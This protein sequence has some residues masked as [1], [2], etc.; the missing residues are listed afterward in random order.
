MRILALAFV[1]ALAAP[2]AAAAEFSIDMAELRRLADEVPGAKP[3]EIRV[4]TLGHFVTPWSMVIEGG[5]AATV[6]MDLL[7][8][9]L[10]L[11][12]KTL[13]IDTALG[14]ALVAQYGIE[15]WDA[16]ASARLD[17]AMANADTIIV[18]HEHFDHIGRIVA[19]ASDAGLMARTRLTAEQVARPQDMEGVEWPEGVLATY[20][21]LTYER[22]HALAP[23]VVLLKAQGHTPGSQL[24]FVKTAGGAEYLFLGD[25]A[26]QQRNVAEMTNRSA[27]T[28]ASMKE[29][30]AAVTAQLEALYALG[31][32]EPD[33]AIIPGHDGKVVEDL[34]AAGKLTAGFAD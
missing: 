22:V 19:Q 25:V 10:I 23:G 26:W 11:A 17:T 7:A 1:A 13:L 4:E 6:E 9:Q 2:E 21:P 8:Y 18:T 14:E 15:G 33:L 5:D 29:D 28:V 24:V 31:E 16:A 30:N 3:A 27:E 20:T 34:I 12:D 32:A